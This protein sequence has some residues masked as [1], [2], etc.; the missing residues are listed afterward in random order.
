[1]PSRDAF[2]SAPPIPCVPLNTSGLEAALEQAGVTGKTAVG[3][4]VGFLHHEKNGRVFQRTTVIQ[5][6]VAYAFEGRRSSTALVL[7]L[8]ALQNGT[9]NVLAFSLD[10]QRWLFTT[11]K[12]KSAGESLE[13]SGIVF[14]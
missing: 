1:M 12:S 5:E 14:E 10:Q 8:A 13:V 11:G 3:K 9:P 2:D 7:T 4:M 6:S